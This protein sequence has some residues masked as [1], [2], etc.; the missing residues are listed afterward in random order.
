MPST[1]N[2]ENSFKAN[3]YGIETLKIFSNLAET[4]GPDQH[5]EAKNNVAEIKITESIYRNHIEVEFTIADAV[6]LLES[7]RISTGEKVEINLYRQDIES[8]ER[9][10]F[11]LNL[12]IAEIKNLSR[13]RPSMVMMTFRC[14]SEFVYNNQFRTLVRP[15]EGA[16]GKNIKDI[17]QSDLKIDTK[18]L[19]IDEAGGLATGIY[20]RM[21]PLNC[22]EWLGRNAFLE[23]TPYFF[24]ETAEGKVKFE[25][26]SAMFAKDPYDTYRYD[27]F[28]INDIG[29]EDDAVAN[30]REE[31]LKIRSFSSDFNVSKLNA[32]AAGSFGSTMHT[33]DIA[34][35]TF[36]DQIFFNYKGDT[37]L[38]D[39]NPFSEK[40]KFLDKTFDQHTEGKNYFI[41]LN[42]EAYETDN[43]HQPTVPTL[44]SSQSVMYNLNSV[45]LDLQL[46]GD[47]EF[48]IGN[49]IELDITR[50]GAEDKEVATDVYLSG[51]Y[52]V[53]STIHTFGEGGYTMK[54]KVKKDSFIESMEDIQKIT[55]EEEET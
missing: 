29:A 6:S 13:I 15:F 36:D 22:I 46:N 21:K 18:N 35:K 45:T 26:L 10:E 41:S 12:R 31:R 1:N 4:D 37:K 27:P 25:S 47:F 39:N 50:A 40:T 7:Y 19:E 44:A 34:T 28:F 32:G 20:P 48:T 42:T 2:F 53:V 54:A 17:C 14:V 43:Y 55:R 49:V 9:K 51:K 16:I 8:K 23:K 24:F 5:V 38:N 33:Y 52:L 3:G 30:Y 11:L